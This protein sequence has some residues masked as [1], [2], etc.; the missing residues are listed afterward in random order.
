MNKKNKYSWYICDCHLKKKIIR[1]G[2][3]LPKERKKELAETN[4]DEIVMIV[5]SWFLR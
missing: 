1:E 3:N 5:A 2:R 4:S